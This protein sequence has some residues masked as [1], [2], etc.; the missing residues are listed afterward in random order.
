[1]SDCTEDRR[2][3]GGATEPH[4][5]VCPEAVLE[6][7]RTL[8]EMGSVRITVPTGHLEDVWPVSQDECQDEV[9][10]SSAIGMAALSLTVLP[11]TWERWFGFCIRWI[12]AHPRLWDELVAFELPGE[13]DIFVFRIDRMFEV[14]VVPLVV[15]GMSPERG[16]AWRL[17]GS[18]I[19]ISSEWGL[20]AAVQRGGGLFPTLLQH[21]EV[22]KRW[23]VD[24]H[25]LAYQLEDLGGMRLEET[26]FDG[27]LCSLKI[28]LF[29]EMPRLLRQLAADG[30]LS[31]T[32]LAETG[33]ARLEYL[34]RLIATAAALPSGLWQCAVRLGARIICGDEDEWNRH[35]EMMSIVGD[36]YGTWPT[37]VCIRRLDL[38]LDLD[39]L[40]QDPDDL[41]SEIVFRIPRAVADGR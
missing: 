24:L 8:R 36:Q 33:K 10:A 39:A 6:A 4:P 18:P 7:A 40:K 35:T 17:A 16:E 19:A 31:E 2:F 37:E 23:S 34:A 5:R 38:F 30:H 12:S 14:L 28:P 26:R 21:G 20:P 32:C 29:G 25:D 11:E 9:F 13:G 3:E 27:D 22:E 15:R 1:M 41:A